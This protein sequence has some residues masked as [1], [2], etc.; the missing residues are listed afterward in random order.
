MCIYQDISNSNV[1]FIMGIVNATPDSFSD[2]GKFLHVSSAVEHSLKLIEDGADII[3]VG[4][5]SSRPGAKPIS[6]DVELKRVIPIIKEV[7]EKAPNTIISIDTT[8]SEVA[9]AA[10]KVGAQIVNDISGGVLDEQ[11]FNV[12]AKYKVPIII[13]HMQGKPETMQDAPN[14][15]NVVEEVSKY[16][17]DR[18]R[19]AKEHNIKKIIID[20]GI[21]FGKRVFENYELL[22]NI[23]YFKSLNYP[24]LV[25]LSKKSFLGKALNLNVGERENAT[26][27]AESFAIQNG[28]N[29]IR[30]HNVKNVSQIKSINS[31]LNNPQ[32][33]KNV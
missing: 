16:F 13:M 23:N 21:G 24:I 19:I 14:Y 31:F 25:G 30:T 28:A 17:E 26:A 2:G 18:I 27:I 6:I 32:L 29:I 15:K 7:I 3:D 9:E 22:K 10:L 4:G 5:E 8:K 12:V 20:P 11:M 33:L 1:P